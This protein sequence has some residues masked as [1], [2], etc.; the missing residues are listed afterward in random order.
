M[1]DHCVYNIVSCIENIVMLI[2]IV[3][4]CSIDTTHHA[5][6]IY[7]YMQSSQSDT[8]FKVLSKTHGII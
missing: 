5:L 8:D 7:S 4:L 1:D 6:A 3:T 2:L